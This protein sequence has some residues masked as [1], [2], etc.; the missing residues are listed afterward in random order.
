MP[1]DTDRT[2]GSLEDVVVIRFAHSYGG[3]GGLSAHLQHLNRELVRRNR[4]TIYQISPT[5]AER[6]PVRRADIGEVAGQL[7]EVRIHDGLDEPRRHA[8]NRENRLRGQVKRLL[9]DRFGMTSSFLGWC[10]E[11]L[12]RRGW[13][14][15]GR[16]LPLVRRDVARSAHIGRQFERELD[17]IQN[18]HRRS[19]LIYIDHSPWEPQSWIRLQAAL[20]ARIG[21]A[22]QH[23]GGF[24]AQMRRRLRRAAARGVAGGAVTLRGHE[25]A[26]GVNPTYLGNGIDTVFFHRRRIERGS[27]RRQLGISGA[28]PLI[29]TP[30]RITPDKGL[31][32]LV[33]AVALLFR[34]RG[35]QA[36]SLVF[37]GQVGDEAY[38]GFL[39]ELIGFLGISD[40]CQ[41]HFVGDLDPQGLRQAYADADLMVLPSYAEGVPRVV[42]EAQA[43]ELPVI[44]TNVGGTCEALYQGAGGTLVTA[45]NVQELAAAIDKM[46]GGH[47]AA[48][49]HM[50]DARAFVARQFGL[51]AL[52]RRHEQFYHSVLDGAAVLPLDRSRTA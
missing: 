14:H 15:V 27:F 42:I 39:E 12:N 41:F 30:A 6:K 8:L 3:S 52:A 32:D 23:H 51:D 44:A 24:T 1:L 45:G 33:D 11:V 34:D 2:N 40:A 43:M 4:I 18:R 25:G 20:R 47:A 22:I 46:I 38:R 36:A 28:V 48:R 9:F 7:I 17:R 49:D 50:S 19:R 37:A 21:V 31:H 13:L 35:W 10:K 29:L 5:H 16:L 26:L